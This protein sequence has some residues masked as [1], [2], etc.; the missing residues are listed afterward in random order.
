MELDDTH[1]LPKND[2]HSYLEDSLK[3]HLSFHHKQV[4]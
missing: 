3:N 2:S 1:E 4:I